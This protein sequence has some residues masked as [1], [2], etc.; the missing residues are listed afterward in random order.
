M[1]LFSHTQKMGSSTHGCVVIDSTGVILWTN[2]ATRRHFGYSNTELVGEN[3]RLLMPP[4]Y[5]EQHD[6]FIRRYLQTGVQHMLGMERLV[7][8]LKKDGTTATAMLAVEMHDI[9]DGH[10]L[11]I[12]CFRFTTADPTIAALREVA[13][14]ADCSSG[15]RETDPDEAFLDFDRRLGGK[16]EAV[17]VARSDGTIVYV[18]KATTDLFGWRAEEL[19]REN[20]T[21]LMGK[22][23]AVLHDGWL[24]RYRRRVVE[25]GGDPASR[26]VGSGRDVFA[27]HRNGAPIR[28]FLTVARLD[29]PDGAAGDF[30]LVGTIQKVLMNAGSLR[31]QR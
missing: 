15:D 11:F 17:V 22:R 10:R 27:K 3:V 12:G 25:R 5:S 20:V 31:V 16:P 30:L 7:P 6:Q 14:R 29:A 2:A 9:G 13:C 26:I 19:R 8:L 28:V 24:E 21:R 1:P 18:N 23:Y 4:P